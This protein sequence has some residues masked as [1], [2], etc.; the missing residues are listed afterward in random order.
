MDTNSQ[1]RKSMPYYFN[2]ILF[3]SMFFVQVAF[4]LTKAEQDFINAVTMPKGL[5]QVG[6]QGGNATVLGPRDLEAVKGA[7]A[8]GASVNTILTEN[9]N[10]TALHIAVN[11]NDIALAAFLL[12]NKANP[13]IKDADGNTPAH[14]AATPDR[15]N[16][17]DMLIKNGADIK[18]KNK[19]GLTVPETL[20]FSGVSGSSTGVGNQGGNANAAYGGPSNLELSQKALNMGANINTQSTDNNNGTVLHIAVTLVNGST[21]AVEFLLKNKANP[22][23]TSSPS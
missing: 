1:E 21:P 3:I 16:L 19:A 18:I 11:V 15:I 13:N 23:L 17:F 9:N 4:G 10:S 7:I 2:I 8:A 22:N 5:A 20:L 12:K 14:L 6:N